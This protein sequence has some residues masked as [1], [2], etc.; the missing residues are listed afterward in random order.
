[1]VTWNL[2]MLI[3]LLGAAA[4]GAS[5]SRELPPLT[6]SA[7]VNALTG[8]FGPSI[9]LSLFFLRDLFVS[10]AIIVL[11]W[12]YIRDYLWVALGVVFV[13][14]I[15]KLTDPIIFRPTILLFMLAGCTLRAQHIPLSSLAKP[16]VF[17]FGILGSGTVLLACHYLLETHGG[18]V[19]DIQNIAR[20]GMLVFAVIAV[21]VLI[22]HSKRLQAFFDHLEPVAF[23][24]Y[25][26]HAL[27]AKL[28]WIAM[29]PLGLSLMG[30]SYLFYFFMAP[31]LMFALV[32]P[33]HAL[34]NALRM[35][36][37]IFLQGKS[38]KKP[39]KN[40]SEPMLGF[41]LR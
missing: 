16:P 20:R 27:L 31:M 8:L 11:T 5:F 15:F 10:T 12:R 37:P 21:A 17:F 32:F 28:I 9:N 26:S 33:L 7:L 29:A 40:R 30:P 13:V 38:A 25:L 2:I 18:P 41:R 22:G 35:P 6:P 24:A 39:K 23:L 19:S 14:T 34:I 4:I 3:A 36:L 1:M